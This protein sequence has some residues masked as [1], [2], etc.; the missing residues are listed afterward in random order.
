[1]SWS[2]ATEIRGLAGVLEVII[3]LWY[4]EHRVLVLMA[5]SLAVIMA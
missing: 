4:A 2:G 3:A 5:D 1:M